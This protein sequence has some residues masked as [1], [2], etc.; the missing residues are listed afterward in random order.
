MG[1][2]SL[3]PPYLTL[4]YTVLKHAQ[5]VFF[6]EVRPYSDL[7]GPTTRGDADERLRRQF[8]E[9]VG[10]GIAIP[11]L[12]GVSAMGTRL[13][14]YEYT[15]ATNTL[16]PPAITFDRNALND[17]APKERW[18]YDLLDADGEEKFKAMVAD[19]KAMA[20]DIE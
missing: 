15:K 1:P 13:S 6:I 14:I 17:V 3:D 4:F 8:R 2:L 16:F 7:K 10:G 11:R 9:L 12:Y 18:N 5:P 19:I 20:N